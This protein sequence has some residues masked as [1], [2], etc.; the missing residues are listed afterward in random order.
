M[1]AKLQTHARFLKQSSG[2]PLLTFRYP[3]GSLIIAV[4]LDQMTYKGPF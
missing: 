1:L 2:A 4:M 3:F